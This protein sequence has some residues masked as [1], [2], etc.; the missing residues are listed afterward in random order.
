M[1]KK[2]RS[3]VEY[4]AINNFYHHSLKREKRRCI[5]LAKE[6]PYRV[7]LALRSLPPAEQEELGYLRRIAANAIL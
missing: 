6:D 5:V 1:V 7:L 2:Y 3:T 4:T